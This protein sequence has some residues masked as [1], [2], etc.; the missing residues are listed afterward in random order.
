MRS[1]TS[2]LDTSFE[3]NIL[4]CFLRNFRRRG[5]NVGKKVRTTEEIAIIT[6]ASSQFCS[7]RT[8]MREWQVIKC[9]EMF[10]TVAYFIQCY[11]CSPLKLL[12]DSNTWGI[13]CLLLFLSPRCEYHQPT[14]YVYG[15]QI[16][17]PHL[18]YENKP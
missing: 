3:Y 2:F 12:T 17:I 4:L 5:Y 6:F 10:P 9:C 7:F 16:R 14:A 18:L 15:L 13:D 11:P 8:M 1:F